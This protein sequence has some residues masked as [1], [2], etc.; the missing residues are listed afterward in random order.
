MKGNITD[1]KTEYERARVCLK[2]LRKE[3]GL[4]QEAMARKFAVGP[5]TIALWELGKRN[6]SGPA[7]KLLELLYQ[8]YWR[9]HLQRLDRERSKAKRAERLK[10]K[11]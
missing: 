3:L 5:G 8:M 1:K 7:R 9:T 11:N 2:N 4:S 10:R 6:M